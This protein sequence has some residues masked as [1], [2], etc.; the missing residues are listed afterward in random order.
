MTVATFSVISG[1]LTAATAS[2]ES[3]N[4]VTPPFLLQRAFNATRV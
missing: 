3:S 4:T 2:T 1:A